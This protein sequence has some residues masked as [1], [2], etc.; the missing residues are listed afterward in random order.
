MAN[1]VSNQ[2]FP[3]VVDNGG[4]DPRSLVRVR[5]LRERRPGFAARTSYVV[6][7]SSRVRDHGGSMPAGG[8]LVVFAMTVARL[9]DQVATASFSCWPTR[10]SFFPDERHTMVSQ[11]FFCGVVF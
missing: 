6:A 3:G 4:G 10:N 11:L 2:S 8:N 1:L 5:V 7:S 9:P